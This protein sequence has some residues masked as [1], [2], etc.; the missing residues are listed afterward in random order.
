MHVLLRKIF[1]HSG[2][3]WQLLLAGFGFAV[4]FWLMLSSL[5]VYIQV[6]KLMTPPENAPQDVI[7]SKKISLGDV[8]ADAKAGFGEGDIRQLQAQPFVE[9]SVPFLSSQFEI[10]AYADGSIPF[11]TEMF[12]EAIPDAFLDTI[13]DGWRWSPGNNF[14]PI[15]LSRD[16]LNLYNFGYAP[17]KGLPKL[18]A[19]MVGI[20][21]FKLKISGR[22]GSE[23]LRGKV[24]GFSERIPTILVPEEFL[25]WANDKYGTKASP[26][27]TRLMTRLKAGTQAQAQQYFD[28][29][30]IEVNQET[31]RLRYLAD[32]GGVITGLIG[33]LGAAFLLLTVML[34]MMNFRLIL[35]EA[36][37]EVDLLLYLGYRHTHLAQHLMYYFSI[38]LLIITFVVVGGGLYWFVKQLYHYLNT[39]TGIQV[40]PSIEPLVLLVGGITIVVILLINYLATLRLLQRSR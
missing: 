4:G 20:L 18:P 32:L 36:K 27:P 5:Q 19:S 34:F 28:M 2:N 11:A 37:Q 39:Q 31:M 21:R 26:P 6:Q 17:S 24:V 13:P 33:V 7:L 1:I 15:I 3:R 14:V 9:Q 16:F 8:L 23:V 30:D 35:A 29:A 12:F 40:N 25:H 10:W 38:F 22:G